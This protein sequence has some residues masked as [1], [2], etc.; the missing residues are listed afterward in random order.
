MT[1]ERKDLKKKVSA[2]VLVLSFSRSLVLSLHGP[3]SRL[4][5]MDGEDIE[6]QQADSM[7]R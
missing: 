5:P 3:D 6:V 2:F 1:L 7:T 4:V